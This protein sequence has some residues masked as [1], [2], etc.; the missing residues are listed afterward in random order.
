MEQSNTTKFLTFITETV[1]LKMREI[2][3]EISLIS[4]ENW[5]RL[6]D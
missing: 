2:Q 3:A 5:T 4:L 1:C 6:L